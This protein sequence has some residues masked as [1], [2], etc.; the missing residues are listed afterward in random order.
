MRVSPVLS[1]RSVL[2]AETHTSPACHGIYLGR[3]ALLTPKEM[4]ALAESWRP[5]RSLGEFPCTGTRV[6]VGH[7]CR[8]AED[9]AGVYYMWAL[10]EEPK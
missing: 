3:G 8:D 9:C 1:V 6:R 10:S 2:T 7:C 5:Y 4:E